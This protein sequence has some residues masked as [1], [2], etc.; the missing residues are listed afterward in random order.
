[1]ERV[2]LLAHFP[3]SGRAVPELERPEIRELLI[4]AYRILYHR[5]ERQITV[6]AVLHDRRLLDPHAV[7]PQP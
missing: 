5:D 3:D 6:L 2:R 4:G 1:M 7:D